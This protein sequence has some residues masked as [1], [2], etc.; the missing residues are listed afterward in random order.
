MAT[1][2]QPVRENS[3]PDL[4]SPRGPTLTSMRLEASCPSLALAFALKFKSL[5]RG[6]RHEMSTAYVLL[7]QC[8]PQKTCEISVTWNRLTWFIFLKFKLEQ[9]NYEL[10]F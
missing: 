9:Q 7:S 4:L 8:E 5:G 10:Y 1:V 3:L 6:F 2:V